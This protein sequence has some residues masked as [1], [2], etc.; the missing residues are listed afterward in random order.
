M[1]CDF[2]SKERSESEDSSPAIDEKRTQAHTRLLLFLLL[3]ISQGK[4]KI[5]KEA[6]VK[7]TI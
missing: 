2:Y 4:K 1:S 5:Q 6:Q 7:V 3:K